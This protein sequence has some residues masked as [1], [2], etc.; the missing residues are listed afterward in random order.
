MAIAHIVNECISEL[1][2]IL[3]LHALLGFTLHRLKVGHIKYIFEK[4]AITDVLAIIETQ[5]PFPSCLLIKI[6]PLWGIDCRGPLAVVTIPPSTVPHFN[7]LRVN[8]TLSSLE[9]RK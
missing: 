2:N 5:V 8:K 3:R 7:R 9:A 1:L 6:N 4:F